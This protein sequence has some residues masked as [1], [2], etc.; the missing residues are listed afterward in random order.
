M[1]AWISAAAAAPTGAQSRK[2]SLS[3]T[4]EDASELV[5]W[6][7][8]TFHKDKS[9]SSGSWGS[10]LGTYLFSGIR[11]RSRLTWALPG[12]QRAKNEEI[13]IDFAMAE[14]VKAGMK[15]RLRFTKKS[16]RR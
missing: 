11:R 16:A 6:L 2:R 4:V 7:C 12:G 3:I 15:N 5:N 1:V 13:S 8:E 9:S 10:E 14:A